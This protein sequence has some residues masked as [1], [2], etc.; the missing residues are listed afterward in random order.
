MHTQTS[1]ESYYVPGTRAGARETAKK[2]EGARSRSNGMLPQDSTLGSTGGLHTGRL[3]KRSKYL[4]LRRRGKGRH[5]LRKSNTL[6]SKTSS[7]NFTFVK[8]KKNIS[9]NH[10]QGLPKELF[11]T[12]KIASRQTSPHYQIKQLPMCESKDRQN[13]FQETYSLKLICGPLKFPCC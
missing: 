13:L 2:T 12:L 3:G 7:R 11:K 4:S 9:Q 5:G 1:F 6:G 10:L 8:E